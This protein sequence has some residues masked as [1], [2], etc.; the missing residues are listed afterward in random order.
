MDS[1]RISSDFLVI[2]SGIA[3]MTYALQMAKTGTVTVICK[4]DPTEG[5]TRYAQGGIASVTSPLD[6]FEAHIEDTLEAGAGLCDRKMVELLVKEGPKRVQELIDLGTN[7]DRK[8]DSENYALG[9]EGGHSARRILHAGDATGAEIQRAVYQQVSENPNIRVIPHQIAIDFILSESPDSETPEV[10]G[11]YALDISSG[12]VRTYSARATML[13]SGGAGTVYLYTSNPVVATGD[14]IAMAFRAGAEVANMEFFQFHP[15]CLFNAETRSFLIT[16]AM[17]G[18]GAILKRADGTRFMSEYDSRKELA[19][20]DIVARAIDDQMKKTGDDYVLLDISHKDEGFLRKRFPTIYSNL[21]KL[22]IDISREPIPVV[23]AA[24]Y[25]CGGVLTDSHGKTS[26][27]RLYATGET[28]CTGVHGAN[29][30]AS[31]SLLEA[32]VFSHRAAEHTK[33]NLDQLKPP[34]AIPRWDYLDTKKS[35]EEVLVSH[36]WGE[37]RRLMWNLV[38]IVRSNKRLKLARARLAL[39][40]QEIKEYYWNFLVT[41]D[42]IEL[43]NISLVAQ[44][45]V[46]SAMIRKESRGLHYN[47]SYPDLNDSEGLK[48]TVVS[49]KTVLKEQ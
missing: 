22:N 10:L 16:E 25:C 48:N 13:A 5:S 19:P 42:L 30:L 7:F 23:P 6:S 11:T 35:K 47:T 2:G 45:I 27:H 33:K 38:G 39:I 41:R 43:R 40:D 36:S 24:H 4:S 14:G 15:T 32:L 9:Q 37:I 26:L 3:G 31:N 20:R 49:K 18:E 21:E 12:R 29:R 44:L 34:S 8:D 1:D 46:E 28:A 17:R